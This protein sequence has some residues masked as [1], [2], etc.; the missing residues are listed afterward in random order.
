MNAITP[1]L[2][3]FAKLTAIYKRVYAPDELLT[4]LPQ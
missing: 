4:A 2:P 1:A 3:R